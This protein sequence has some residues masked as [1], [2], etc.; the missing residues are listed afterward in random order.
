MKNVL[1]ITEKKSINKTIE[2][3]LSQEET[4]VVA[5][6]GG[7]IYTKDETI[8]PT[9][10]ELAFAKTVTLPNG[11][12]GYVLGEPLINENV[13]QIKKLLLENDFDVI[14]NACDADKNGEALFE[15][16]NSLVGFD[17]DK[18]VRLKLK[19]LTEEHI[20]KEYHSIVSDGCLPEEIER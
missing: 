17:A 20:Q 13:E 4:K 7:H 12:T 16:A 2:K 15:Y 1:I 10:D 14:V 18:V 5:E 8:R 11:T 6:I 3:A 19:D 9:Q